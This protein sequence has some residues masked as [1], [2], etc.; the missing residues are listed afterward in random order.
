LPVVY[1]FAQVADSRALCLLPDDRGGARLAVEHLIRQG[2]RRIAHVT[3]PLDFEAVRKRRQGL[4]DALA[5][6]GLRSGPGHVLAGT[7]SEAFGRE[8]AQQLIARRPAVDAIFCGSD[9]IARGVIDSLRENGAGV[10]DDIAVVG[11]DN[12][13][14]IAAATRPPITTVDM[15]LH[16]LGRQAG[17]RLL[18]MVDGARSSGVERLPCR[19]IVRQS[20]GASTTALREETDAAYAS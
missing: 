20:C 5:A 3:G 16:E 15:N 8:A 14:V 9:Q 19:L 17:V 4:R 18:A 10:P 12:W 13:D 6:A 11:F 7:W 2:R 1:A